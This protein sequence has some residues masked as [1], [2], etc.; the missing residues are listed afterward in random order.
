[1]SDAD[2]AMPDPL[3][4]LRQALLSAAERDAASAVAAAAAD[5]ETTRRGAAQEADAVRR[6]ARAQGEAEGRQVLD[7]E[8]ARARRRARATVLSAQGE[9]Y[10]RLRA[11]ARAAVV[12]LRDEPGYPALRDRLGARAAGMVGAGAR[13]TESPDGGV[14]AEARGRRAALTL[15][16]LADRALDVPGLDLEA[17]WT[18]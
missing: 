1:M 7:A 15:A 2:T 11:E 6:R 9:A 3:A 4:P 16:A 5:A 14:V 17:L 12:A 18:L 10:A 13:V 8:R